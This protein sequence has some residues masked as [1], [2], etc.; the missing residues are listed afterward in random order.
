MCLIYTTVVC[1]IAQIKNT[2]T[3]CVQG[4][5]NQRFVISVL[6]VHVIAALR[7]RLLCYI[8]V[9]Y[10]CNSVRLSCW[11]KRLLLLLL[12]FFPRCETLSKVCELSGW[13]LLLYLMAFLMRAADHHLSESGPRSQSHVDTVK[14]MTD[15]RLEVDLEKLND[16]L[17]TCH[18]MTGGGGVMT[19]SASEM[20]HTRMVQTRGFRIPSLRGTDGRH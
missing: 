10:S 7:G 18:N 20:P 11:I 5:I 9:N 2:S 17:M 3:K 6:T 12:F 13:P 19:T 14:N 1:L 4:R 15:W 16:W 8:Y